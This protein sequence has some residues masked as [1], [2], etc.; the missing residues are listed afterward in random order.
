MVTSFRYLGRAISAADDEWTEVVMDLS[1]DRY[2]CNIMTRI[3][4]RE[5]VKRRVSRFLFI[6]MVQAVLLFGTE[7]WVATPR[8]GRVMG[9]FQ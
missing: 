6:A 2:V 5:G 7:T 3:I 8:T 9:W 1:R 4:I